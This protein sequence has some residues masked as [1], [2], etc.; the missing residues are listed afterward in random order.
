MKLSFSKKA[1]NCRVP[2]VHHLSRL[3]DKVKREFSELLCTKSCAWVFFV[4]QALAGQRRY[5]VLPGISR[6][7]AAF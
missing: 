4:E 6:L 7:D 5:Y 2:G 1:A 3:L